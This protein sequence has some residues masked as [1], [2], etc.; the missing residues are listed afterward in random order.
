MSKAYG[1]LWWVQTDDHVM[2]DARHILRDALSLVAKHDG[3][4][5]AIA[6]YG[7]PRPVQT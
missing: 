3:I 4:K 2:H 7:D 5:E 1:R 6:E